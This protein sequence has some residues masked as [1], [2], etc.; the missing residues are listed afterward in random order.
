MLER[1]RQFRDRIRG[2]VMVSWGV[3]EA[4]ALGIYDLL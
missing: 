3:A 4:R 1:E 2:E